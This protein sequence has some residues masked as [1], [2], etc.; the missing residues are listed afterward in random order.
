MG[1]EAR[2][3][4]RPPHGLDFPG[5]RQ[6]Q[7][8]M[9]LFFPVICEAPEG[10]R[11]GTCPPPSLAGPQ[12][13]CCP[14]SQV[15]TGG[16]QR[17]GRDE[18][19]S[20][21]QLH[22]VFLD[23][24]WVLPVWGI[25]GMGREEEPPLLPPLPH[26]SDATLSPEWKMGQVLAREGPPEPQTGRR[27]APAWSTGLRFPPIPACAL[28]AQRGRSPPCRASLERL[29]AKPGTAWAALRAGAAGPAGV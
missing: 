4:G 18:L 12:P 11:G 17:R 14:C 2:L 13:E 23:V 27:W 15:P 9:L 26:S 8:G 16:G 21:R 22:P 25:R 6:Q 1:L 19:Q 7:P 10:L 20:W 3:V 24:T 29:V 28:W 5:L